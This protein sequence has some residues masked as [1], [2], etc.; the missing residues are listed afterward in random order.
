MFM[1]IDLHGQY[2]TTYTKNIAKGYYI[3]DKAAQFDS[4]IQE[5]DAYLYNTA[6]N[7][8]P[9]IIKYSTNDNREYIS[10]QYDTRV[11][12]SE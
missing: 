11:H 3:Q 1:D 5:T 7:Q 8:H 4:Y 6:Y 2:G 9:D 12:Y 10:Q